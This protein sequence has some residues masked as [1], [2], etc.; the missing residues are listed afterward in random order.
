MNSQ[1]N[2]WCGRRSIDRYI[3]RLLLVAASIFLIAGCDGDDG[4]AG[5]AGAAAG[6]EIDADVDTDG[7]YTVT[8]IY[9]NN[10]P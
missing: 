6:S 5:A 3:H 1:N 7:S 8:F 4:A 2:E 10:L 9:H